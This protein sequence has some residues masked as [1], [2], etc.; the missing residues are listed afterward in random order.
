MPSCSCPSNQILHK[1][2]FNA[3]W[4]NKPVFLLGTADRSV[5]ID[6][7]ASSNRGSERFRSRQIRNVI[8][9]RSSDSSSFLRASLG[10]LLRRK[11]RYRMRRS[12]KMLG[13]RND[14]L[15]NLRKS[16]PLLVLGF[17]V[18]DWAGSAGAHAFIDL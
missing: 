13:Y 15:T 5:G 7:H 2:R 16:T 18:L 8:L 3:C 10:T 14:R 12:G 17:G 1:G 4:T 6:L 9:G 11:L